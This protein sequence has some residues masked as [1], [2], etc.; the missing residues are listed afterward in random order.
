M[1]VVRWGQRWRMLWP[2]ELSSPGASSCVRGR[3]LQTLLCDGGTQPWPRGGS[4]CWGALRVSLIWVIFYNP[5]TCTALQA[6]PQGKGDHRGS[7]SMS[8][9]EISVIITSLS[10]IRD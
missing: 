5:D 8:L 3:D 1:E 6:L 2:V 10:P 4:S 7:E 9:N